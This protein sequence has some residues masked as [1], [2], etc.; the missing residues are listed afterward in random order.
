[1]FEQR[2]GEVALATDPGQMG[3]DAHIVFIGTI[4]S[5]W[6]SRADCPKNIRQ[7]RERKQTASIV[8]QPPYRPGL[9]GVEAGNPVI[10]LSWLGHAPRDLIVQKPRHADKPR[11]TFALRSPARP[12]PIGLHVVE[13]L[14]IDPE[15]GILEID[16]IDVLDKT[17]LIDLKPWYASTD[18]GGSPET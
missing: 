13:L 6:T 10:L 1:M 9:R 2:S 16:A 3:G 14:A 7:A 4:R 18:I 5:P 12:N 15:T 11:G 8:I 17:P